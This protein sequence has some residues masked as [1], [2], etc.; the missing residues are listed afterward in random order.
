MN[1]GNITEDMNST[2][3]NGTPRHSSMKATQ[4]VRITG[5]SERL[6]SASTMPNG[7]EPTMPR[8]PITSV[9]NRPPQRVVSTYS[10][11]KES[12]TNKK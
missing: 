7:R 11:P 6:P 9:R 8:I 10:S 1:R 3:I 2:V 4:R 5:I 12:P